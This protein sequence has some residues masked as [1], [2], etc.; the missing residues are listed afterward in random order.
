MINQLI[1]FSKNRPMQLHLLLESIAKNAVSV[2]DNITVLY[3]SDSLYESGYDILAKHFNYIVFHKESDFRLDLLSLIDDNYSYTT[4]MVD[5]NLFYNK[6]NCDLS[7]ILG[8]ITDNHICFSLRLGL[9]CN[10]SH[11]A[12]FSYEIGKYKII[13][14]FIT[15]D[16]TTQMGDFNYPLSTDGHIYKTGTIKSILTAIWFTNPNTMESMMQSFCNSNSIPKLLTFFNESKVV[17]VPVNLV[18]DGFNNRHGIKHYFSESD[19]NKKYLNEYIIDIESLDFSDINGPH[20]EIE[21]KFK[22][23][24]KEICY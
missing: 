10:Y 15:V 16:Y 17:G 7:D 6:I 1:I 9:N 13:D 20:K 3:K 18:N 5:D 11:P 23:K 19:L 22:M 4:F 12:D 2:F 8:T 21:Y 14:N 24:N